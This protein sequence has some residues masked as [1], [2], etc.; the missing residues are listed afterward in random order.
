MGD[1]T[2]WNK[3]ELTE[4]VEN[5]QKEF[6]SP[7]TRFLGCEVEKPIKIILEGD[8]LSKEQ[9]VHQYCHNCGSQRCEG[10]GTEWFDGCHYKGCLR[11]E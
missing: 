9:F 10:I 11:E 7:P 5:M 8:M 1:I 4:W 2:F 6:C 3:E